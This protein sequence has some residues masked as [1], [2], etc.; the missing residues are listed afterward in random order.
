MLTRENLDIIRREIAPQREPVISLFLDVNRANPDNARGAPFVRV[1]DELKRLGLPKAS[2][3]D[4]LE[5]LE[6]LARPN[7]ARTLVVFADEDPEAFFRAYPSQLEF[8]Q[9]GERGIVARWGKPFITPL[10]QL[11]D[12]QE[13]WGVVHL[14]QWRWRYFEIYFG[15][16]EELA[17]AFRALDPRWWRS[18]GETKPGVAQGVV[19]RG[20][21]GKDQFEERKGAWT[22]RFY[23]NMAGQLQRWVERNDVRHVALIGPSASIQDYLGTLPANLRKRVAACLPAPANP[24][25]R[26]E[27]ILDLVAPEIDRL[28]EEQ[29]NALLNEISESGIQGL[30]ATLEALQEGRLQV[31]VAPWGLD[32]TAYLCSE[33]GYVAAT[34]ARSERHCPGQHHQLILL[35]EVLPELAEAF[36][37]RLTYVRGEAETMLAGNHGGLAGLGRW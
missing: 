33:S 29:T 37:T 31:L 16:I 7:R 27:D 25:A 24:S 19:A 1:K 36:G 11:I 6:A 26:S 14:D 35:Q 2:A 28:R 21:S 13:R 3:A 32:R 10:L 20:G 8:P 4:L 5:R 17:D 18:L 34:L 12:A 22:H 15:E 30:E 23:R 9:L